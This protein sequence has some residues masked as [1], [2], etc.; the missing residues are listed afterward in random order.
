MIDQ[1]ELKAFIATAR[2]LSFLHA[3]KEL[4]VSPSQISKTIAELER[5]VRKKLFQRTTRVV[6]LSR[7]GEELL[8]A[9]QRAL[10][11]LHDAEEFFQSKRD[12]FQISGTIRTTCSNA[13]GIRRLAPIAAMFHHA[14]PEIKMEFLLSDSYTDIIGEGIDVAI[15]I[16]KPEDSSLIARRIADNKIIFCASPKYLRSN[17]PIKTVKDLERHPIFYIPQH[18]PLVFRKAGRSLAEIALQKGLSWTTAQSGDFLVELAQQDDS[19]VLVRSE[20]GA[21]REI[22]VGTLVPLSINDELISETAIYA[23]YAANKYM[24]KRLRIWLDFLVEKFRL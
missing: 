21:E 9:A 13:L 18:G 17:G 15:R 22:A 2:H 7:D 24:P 8:P 11:A 14:Y 3:A 20:W 16:M 6:R 19:G 4:R 1:F 5:K 12:D 23:V 10:E